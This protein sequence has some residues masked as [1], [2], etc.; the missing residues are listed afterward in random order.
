MRIDA[1]ASVGGAFKGYFNGDFN[2]DGDI[3][4]DDYTIIDGNMPIQ[5]SPL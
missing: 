3:N 4:I 1:S 5:G 2:Y